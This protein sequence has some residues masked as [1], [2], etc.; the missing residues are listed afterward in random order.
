MSVKYLSYHQEIFMYYEHYQ[1]PKYTIKYEVPSYVDHCHATILPRSY[2]QVYDH[3]IISHCHIGSI[4]KVNVIK[5]H[6]MRVESWSH[7]LVLHKIIVTIKS[8]QN[9][10]S[11]LL[12][13]VTTRVIVS[14]SIDKCYCHMKDYCYFQGH[15]CLLWSLSP[16]FVRIIV[17][18]WQGY[19]CPYH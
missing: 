19:L 13:Q 10:I 6:T 8:S 2:H 15:Y 3:G 1:I 12:S 5:Y 4:N 18:Y 14:I 9:I 16:N 7:Y 11:M 17:I